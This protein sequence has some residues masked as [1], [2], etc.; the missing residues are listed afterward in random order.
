[1]KRIKWIIASLA[2]AAVLVAVYILFLAPPG[3]DRFADDPL[4]LKRK[5]CGSGDALKGADLGACVELGL[6]LLGREERV[7]PD[8]DLARALFKRTCDQAFERGCIFL[9]SFDSTRTDFAEG[10]C[11]RGNAGA[12]LAVGRAWE[13]GVGRD[14]KWTEARKWY[15]KACQL[16][17]Q[18]GCESKEA[19]VPK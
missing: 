12:C 1:M 11:T 3:R 15:D 16:G 5:E 17:D 6:D 9:Q 2:A 19:V 10:R 8:E 14:R 18:K 4:W 7:T 13:E